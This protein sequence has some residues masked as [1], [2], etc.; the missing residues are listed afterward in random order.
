[1]GKRLKKSSR[2]IGFENLIALLIIAGF[3]TIILFQTTMLN[4]T[5]RVYLN[6]TEKIEGINVNTY[7][8][9]E[10]TLK[11]EVINE[12][13]AN[14]AYILVDGEPKG[15]FK[16]KYI[17]IKVKSGQLIEIDGSKCNTDMYFK[18]S[19][20]SDNV[21]EPQKTAIVKVEKNIAT[22]GRVRLK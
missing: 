4:S 19:D 7:L 8:S 1:M 5:L 20:I 21:I 12:E 17:N 16:N 11:I 22:V 13:N 10:G 18:I 14:N 3:I 15:N 2:F 6:S 9:K